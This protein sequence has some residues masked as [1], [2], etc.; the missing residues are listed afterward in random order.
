MV[1]PTIISPD[2]TGFI[3]GHFSF[4]NIRHLCNILYCPSPSTDEN[5]EIIISLDAEKAF[6]PVGWDYLFKSLESLKFGPK[7]ISWVRLLYTFPMAAVRTYNNISNYFELQ[8]GTRQGCPLSPLLFAVAMEP[9]ALALRQSP[10]IKGILRAGLEH[11]I[12]LYADDTLL[13][14]SDPCS[15]IPQLLSLLSVFG[16]MSG[17]K[18]NI[19]KSELMPIS[20]MYERHVMSSPFKVN[21]NKIKYLGVWITRHYKDLFKA[22]YQPLLSNLKQDLNRWD[23]LPLSLG[24]RINSIKM[25]VLPKFLYMFQC[26]PIFLTKSFFYNLARYLVLYGIIN[27]HEYG[28]NLYSFL[29][30]WGAYL[31]QIFCTIIGEQILGHCYT[32]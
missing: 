2:Q 6:D 4:F 22:N 28:R 1:I 20:S 19:Q 18:V 3:K 11:K 9:L 31:F 14:I 29:E 27:N 13:F 8:H 17:Y 23:A 30:Q 21:I 7:F 24:G 10:N 25:C 26:L 15:S 5:G 12:S 32:G 16:K